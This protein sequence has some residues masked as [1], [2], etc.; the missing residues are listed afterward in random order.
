MKAEI[1]C[2]GTELLLG[3]IVNTNAAFIAKKLA[4]LGIYCYYQSVVGDNP[5]RLSV[6]LSE[7]LGRSE[8]IIM[9]GGLGPTYDDLT[10]ETVARH[11]GREL[12]L[13]EHSLKR[14]RD[15]LTRIKCPIT[16]N[17]LKQA[18]MPVGAVVFDNDYGTA[19][20]LAIEDHIDD[21]ANR[22]VVIMLPGPPREME[23]MFD[24]C[25]VPYLRKFSEDILVSSTV[26][27]YG[28]GESAVEDKLRALME[29]AVNPTV[30]PY[31]K[32]GEVQ[33]R[34]TASGKDEETCRALIAPVIEQ[35]Y[36]VLGD[37]IYGVDIPSLQHLIVS[38]L[39]KTGK[40]LAVAESCT[41]G[42]IAKSITDVAGSSAVF[43][44]GV[45]TYANSMKEKL[46]GVSAD[47]L[48]KY[49]AVSPQCAEEMAR[50][51]AKLAGADY[52]I[53]TTGI[54]GPGGGTAEKPVG[55]VYVG[56]Y[57]EGNTT[58]HKL[59]LGRGGSDEREVIRSAAVKRA[60]RLL[61][62]AIT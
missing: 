48:D 40:K 30:A 60:L 26:H 55:L 46:L 2:V 32:E 18:Y 49:G 47:T 61:I 52:A 41:G 57:A 38:K 8:L 31:C 17:N 14:I 3:D 4:S 20:A 45:V 7:S 51:A 15:R 10:K 12:E 6:S 13:H 11:F 62:D 37:V 25:I 39:A 50:G 35:I 1:L 33:L 22:R 19:P 28:M 59:Q 36:S 53:A 23:P 27:I 56:I 5:A 29:S 21:P 24:E 54:A 16:E 58:V 34:V 42:Y 44:C 43:D 9:T